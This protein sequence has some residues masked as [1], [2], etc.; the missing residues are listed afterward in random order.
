MVQLIVFYEELQNICPQMYL[1]W[2]SATGLTASVLLIELDRFLAIRF[3][4]K[5]PLLI[6]DERALG[7]CAI[8]QLGSLSVTLAVRIGSA[9]SFACAPL[10]SGHHLVQRALFL[11]IV[12]IP[13]FI[14]FLL[15][16]VCALYVVKALLNQVRKDNKVSES[17]QLQV[18][19]ALSLTYI[20]VI[21]RSTRGFICSTPLAERWMSVVAKF[22][23]SRQ[24]ATTVMT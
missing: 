12:V 10:H 23:L 24:S 21:C 15:S 7:A 4:F 13:Y 18:I 6:T 3:P 19:I 8:T 1:I 2:W 14:C 9:D 17:V 22:S 20:Y 11:F 16:L 5:Y